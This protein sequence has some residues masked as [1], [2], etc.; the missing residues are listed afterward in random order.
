MAGVYTK[1]KSTEFI[2]TLKAQAEAYDKAVNLVKPGKWYRF[3]YGTE[4]EY[5]EQYHEYLSY[6]L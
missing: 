2:E 4:E 3:R 6:E 1:T 5:E